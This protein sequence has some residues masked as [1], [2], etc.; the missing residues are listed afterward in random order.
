MSEVF[1]FE[2]FAGSG[3]GLRAR[4]ILGDGEAAT[5]ENI[6]SISYRVR[7]VTDGLTSGSTDLDV[8]EVLFATARAWTKYRNGYTFLFNAPGTLWPDPNK[9][10]RILVTF[11][12]KDA[13][14]DADT[15]RAFT[16]V[17]EVTTTDPLGS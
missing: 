4:P 10:Y 5:P 11:V 3:K 13:N 17:W 6:Y 8:D 9:V 14:G 2:R 7:N 15:Q 16:E 12:P 1:S